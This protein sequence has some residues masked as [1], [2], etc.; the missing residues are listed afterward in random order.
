LQKYD[1]LTAMSGDPRRQKYRDAIPAMVKSALEELQPYGVPSGTQGFVE[2]KPDDLKFPIVGY[3]DYRWES[4]GIIL[5]LKTTDKMPSSIKEDHALQVAFYATQ[6]GDNADA[7]LAYITPNK[8]AIYRLENV[9]EHLNALHQ[10][11]IRAENFLA[12]SEDPEFYTSIIAPNF[13]SFYWNSPAARQAGFERWG[14]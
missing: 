9:R 8:R 1:T 7:R 11:A 14:F 5:D 12:L 2:W 13:G 10:I 3:W 6:T 4:H